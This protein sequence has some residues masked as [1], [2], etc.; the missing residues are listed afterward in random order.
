MLWGATGQAKVVRELLGARAQ[1]V[2]MFDNAALASPFEG[3]PIYRGRDGFSEWKGGQSAPYPVFLVAI[4]GDKGRDRVEIQRFLESAGLVAH[5]AVHL[6]AFVADDAVI[7]R[8][9]QICAQAAVCT[10]ARL[11]DG[12]IVNTAASVDH[13]CQ[14]GDGVHIMPGARLAGCITVGSYATIG[15]NAT[16]LPRLRIGEGA[17]VGAGAVV[18]KDVPAGAVVVGNPARVRP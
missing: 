8:G 10:L 14:L 12:C 5:V 7:G 15:T 4:G 6:T 13:E 2:A 9:S 17:M 16:I 1:I 11:G 18:T 3:V